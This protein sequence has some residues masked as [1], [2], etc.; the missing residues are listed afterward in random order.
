LAI[1]KIL[2]LEKANTEKQ[3]Q[4]EMADYLCFN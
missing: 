2:S 4:F 1:L 3:D